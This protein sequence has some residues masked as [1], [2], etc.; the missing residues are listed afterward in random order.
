MSR[1]RLSSG[2]DPTIPSSSFAKGLWSKTDV[3]NV[4]ARKRRTA[5]ATYIYRFA[6]LSAPRDEE[7]EKREIQSEW[8]TY[9]HTHDSVSQSARAM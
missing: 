5:V 4:E 3:K 2:S 9:V 6:I 7:R 1:A 8:I